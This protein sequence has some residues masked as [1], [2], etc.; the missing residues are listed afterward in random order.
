MPFTDLGF[1]QL[2]VKISLDGSLTLEDVAVVGHMVM[3]GRPM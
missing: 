3:L 2:A 1:D